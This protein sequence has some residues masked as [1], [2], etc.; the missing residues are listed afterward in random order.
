[1][2]FIQG[3]F[4]GYLLIGIPIFSGMNLNHSSF[5]RLFQKSLI[6]AKSVRDMIAQVLL[7]S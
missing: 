2:K 3:A 5:Q 1:M 4:E 7:R 6:L